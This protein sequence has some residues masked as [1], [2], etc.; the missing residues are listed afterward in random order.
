MNAIKLFYSMALGNN[1][2]ELTLSKQGVE[3]RLLAHDA[4]QDTRCYS[5][6]VIL[7]SINQKKIIKIV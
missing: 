6:P 3:Q 5:M 2:Y 1:H 4:Q 7:T